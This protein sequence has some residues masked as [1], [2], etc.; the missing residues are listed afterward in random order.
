MLW[1]F[2]NA[3]QSIIVNLEENSNTGAVWGSVQYGGLTYPV[4]GRWQAA[5]SLPGR[6][7]SPFELS[8]AANPPT[9]PQAP[10][11]LALSGLIT[12]SAPTMTS[13]VVGLNVSSSLTGEVHSLQSTLSP[14]TL[15]TPVPGGPGA[16][17]SPVS[18]SP[19]LMASV[20]GSVAMAMNVDGN[21]GVSGTLTIDGAEYDVGGEWAASG[22]L[23]NRNASDFGIVGFH[24]P[25]PALEAVNYLAAAGTMD[26]PGGWPLKVQISGN[27]APIS[28]WHNAPFSETLIPMMQNNPQQ[29]GVAY[30]ESYMVLVIADNAQNIP[31][32]VAGWM[33]QTDSN[34]N[35]QT[36]NGTYKTTGVA[37]TD[38]QRAPIVTPDPNDQ[39]TYFINLP[40][41]KTANPGNRPVMVQFPGT[42]EHFGQPP[43]AEPHTQIAKQFFDENAGTNTG[44]LVLQFD[45]NSN[46]MRATHKIVFRHDAR[47]KQH[48]GVIIQP[49]LF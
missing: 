16:A 23:P 10:N 46:S 26:G 48:G 40:A 7:S 27:I 37:L 18:G 25:N 8:G 1:K 34:G 3:D 12:G 42:A 11:F 28:N 38:A 24:K 17:R 45:N 31:E 30:N 43:L 9:A 32:C 33:G 44:A 19:W 13:M 29:L 5:G 4:T 2:A 49:S 21:G 35:V 20:D 36:V 47:K 14:I 39:F 6:V 41:L 15:N 22:S